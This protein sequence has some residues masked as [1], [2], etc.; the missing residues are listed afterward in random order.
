MSGETN[1]DKLLATMSPSLM[2]GEFVFLSFAN[3]AYGEYA[4]LDPVASIIEAEGLTLVIQKS[5]A[6]R[7]ALEYQSSF[8]GITLGV[9]S[10]L[11]AVGL[12]AAFSVKLTEHGISANVI[13][14]FFHDH[15]FVQVNDAERAI[16]ALQQL[17][18]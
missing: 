15:I 11:D 16:A 3:A 5:Q 4:N 13:A 18:N 17:S 10:S 7:R 14:G 12:T 8:K 1:L 9:H 6:D 2:D